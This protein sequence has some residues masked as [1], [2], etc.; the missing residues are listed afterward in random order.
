MSGTHTFEPDRKYPWFCKRCGYGD[1]ERL[2]H[3]GIEDVYCWAN[4][5]TMVFDARGQ[6]MPEYQGVTDEVMPKIRAAGW[7]G[8]PIHAEW[9]GN[10]SETA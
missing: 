8:E 10:Q 6:Q 9:P 3:H 4:G 5:M 2:K 1:R 7:T